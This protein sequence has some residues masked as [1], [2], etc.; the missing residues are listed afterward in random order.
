M[1]RIS[2][3]TEKLFFGK[4]I[5]ALPVVSWSTGLKP[6]CVCALR[7]TLSGVFFV[8]ISQPNPNSSPN[9]NLKTN[10]FFVAFISITWGPA[11]LARDRWQCKFCVLFIAFSLIRTNMKMR[12]EKKNETFIRIQCGNK[13]MLLSTWWFQITHSLVLLVQ[14]QWIA[15]PFGCSQIY[16]LIK[17][18]FQAF[19]EFVAWNFV[20]KFIYMFRCMPRDSYWS[21]ISP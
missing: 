15:K 20:L 7:K 9:V 19:D 11:R 12:W 4:Q 18:S 16:R 8:Q 21:K 14:S 10:I 1:C 6:F 13:S 5:C 3:R 17:F 2:R